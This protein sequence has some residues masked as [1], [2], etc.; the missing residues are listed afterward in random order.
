MP[1][2]GLTQA[3]KTPQGAENLLSALSGAERLRVSALM[4]NPSGRMVKEAAKIAPSTIMPT[5]NA[6]APE[7][8]N[9]N[10]LAQ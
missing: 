7:S 3:L 10:A 6:L 2:F 8:E 9:V 1:L 5:I 4:Q